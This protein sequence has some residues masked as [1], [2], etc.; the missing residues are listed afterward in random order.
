[1]CA[2]TRAISAFS[3]SIRSFSS[4][5]DSGSRSCLAS[6]TSGSSGLLGK[7]SSR[8]MVESLTDRAAKSISRR[9]ANLPSSMRAVVADGDGRIAIVDR[10]LPQPSPGEVLI[11]VAAAGVNRPDVLQRRGMY[12]PPPGAPDILGLEV[13]GEVVAAGQ[14]AEALIGDKVCALVAGGGYAQY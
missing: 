13:A 5:I 14:G 9:V 6:A 8:S 7:S 10:P 4:S 11:K 3:A 2:S 12:P 1:M